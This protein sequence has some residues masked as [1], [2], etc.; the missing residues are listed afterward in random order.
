[1]N[2]TVH[3]TTQNSW[4]EQIQDFWKLIKKIWKLQQEINKSNKNY[5]G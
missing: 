1:M 2:V 3:G 4:E 5:P